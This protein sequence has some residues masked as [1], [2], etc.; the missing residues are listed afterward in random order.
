MDFRFHSVFV[1]PLLALSQTV[2]L[3][4]SLANVTD[5]ELEWDG[6]WLLLASISFIIFLISFHALHS[7]KYFILF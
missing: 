7:R 6:W 5:K 1:F 3:S 4:L 2:L